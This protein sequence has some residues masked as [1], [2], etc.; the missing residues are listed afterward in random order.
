[1]SLN[2]GDQECN[3]GKKYGQKGTLCGPNMNIYDHSSSSLKQFKDLCKFLCI[4]ST[5][6]A[7]YEDIIHKEEVL[8]ISGKVFTST[9]SHAMKYN[10]L[11]RLLSQLKSS[12]CHVYL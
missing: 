2:V 9:F 3:S 8:V 5:P 11:Q 6:T 4:P 7:E 12:A 10:T 1:M